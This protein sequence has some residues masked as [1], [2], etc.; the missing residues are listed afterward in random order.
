MESQL[1]AGVKNQ[2]MWISSFLSLFGE[3]GKV[4]K[5]IR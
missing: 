2:Q 4:G 1:Y 3:K 5:G